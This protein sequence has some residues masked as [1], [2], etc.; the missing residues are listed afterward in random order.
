MNPQT[1]WNRLLDAVAMRRWQQTERLANRLLDHLRN[2]GQPPRIVRHKGLGRRWHATVAEIVC[3][4]A[5][6]S[7]LDSRGIATRR[8]EL[9]RWTCK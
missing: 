8:R 7:A 9:W 6:N 3:Y 1:T 5:L 4:M 2:R